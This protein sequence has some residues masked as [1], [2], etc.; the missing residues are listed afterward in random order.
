[1]TLKIVGPAAAGLGFGVFGGAL[2]GGKWLRLSQRRPLDRLFF[3]CHKY[4]Y[5]DAYVRIHTY[6]HV[7]TNLFIFIHI[8]LFMYCGKLL[9][10]KL[11]FVGPPFPWL[12]PGVD[13]RGFSFGHFGA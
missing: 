1:M 9:D 7:N 11:F 12:F 3:Y 8:H 6:L 5:I 2:H 4:A 13:S 10:F